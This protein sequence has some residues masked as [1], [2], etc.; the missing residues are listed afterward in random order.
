MAVKEASSGGGLAALRRFYQTGVG[1]G[2]P[3][4]F[5]DFDDVLCL[6][7][8][9]GAYDVFQVTDS[10]PADLFE[11]LWHP[12]A[13]QVLLD[14]VEEHQPRVVITSS[15][16]MLSDQQDAFATLFRLT[17]LAGVAER[18]HEKWEAPAD[19]GMTRLGAIE[20]WLAA[21]YR[22]EPIVVLDDVIS[23]TGL[24]GSRLD[25][26]GCVVLCEQDVGLHRGHLPLVRRVL[27]GASAPAGTSKD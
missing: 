3:T 2:V 9:F 26:A 18:L 25:R 19:R 17:G 6:N 21:H 14:L 8:P 1:F 27:T 20:R 12:P 10:R 11:R 22:G 16:L 4:V 5:L 23:G 24:R 15:W 13:V 7:R